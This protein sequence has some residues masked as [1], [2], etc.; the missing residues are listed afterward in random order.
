V[1]WLDAFRVVH[2]RAFGSI[3]VL[4]ALL[5]G[6]FLLWVLAAQGIY[7]ATLGPADPTSIGAFARDVVGTPAGRMMILLGMGVGFVFAVV[8]LAVSVVSFPMLVDRDVGVGTAV[9]TS[10][11]AVAANLVVIA[12]WGLVVAAVLAVASIP[13]FVGLIVALPV[14]G[15]ATWHLYRRLVP[16]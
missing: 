12:A 7:N 11:R 8:V 10:L 15:H 13:L 4:A 5:A 14:L 3:L 16:V 1:S 6:V 2:A 9:G